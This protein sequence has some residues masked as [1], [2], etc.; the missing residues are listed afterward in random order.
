MLILKLKPDENLEEHFVKLDKLVR[1][2]ETV[3]H[4]MDDNDK[5]YHHLLYLINTK[6]I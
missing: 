3:S 4:K 5:V 2:R 6:Q 1:D